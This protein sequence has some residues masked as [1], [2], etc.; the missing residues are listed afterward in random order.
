M[1]E[2]IKDVTQEQFEAEVLKRSSEKPVVVDFWAAWCA[3]CRALGPVLEREIEALGGRVELA[4]IDVDGNP[5]LA[6]E[7]GIRGIPAVKA[8]RDGRVVDEFE[9]ARDAGF[10]RA[11]LAELVPSPARLAVE[12]AEK[13]VAAGDAS[14]ESELRALLD[15]AEVG[16]RAALALTELLLSKGDADGAEQA[17]K[18]ID[19][20]SPLIDAEPA[21]ERRI[22]FV[23]EAAAY[24]GEEKARAAVEANPDDLEARYALGCALA[25][26]GDLEGALDAFLAIVSRNRKFRDDAARLAMLAIFEQLGP[27]SDLASA[28]RRKL[29]IYL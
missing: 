26:R 11:W 16:S 2:H 9:G 3:P 10:V 15:D 14:A 23:R 6:A 27:D 28:Y 4:K 25:S 12:A 1:S 18:K 22:G 13:K 29:L 8:F 17:L 19:P 24:G 21:L 7:Y 5:S 20:R